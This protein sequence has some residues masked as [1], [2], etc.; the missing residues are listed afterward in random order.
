MPLCSL[1]CGIT[2]S[3]RQYKHQPSFA[4]LSE[5]AAPCDLCKLMKDVLEASGCRKAVEEYREIR[6]GKFELMNDTNTTISA[7][8]TTT[9]QMRHLYH[10]TTISTVSDVWPACSSG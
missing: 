9:R 2:L 7:T 3:A 8:R 1:C 10:S 5:S 4:E 6:D